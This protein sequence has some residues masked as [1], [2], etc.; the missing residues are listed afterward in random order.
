MY[1]PQ[2]SISFF[3]PVHHL[4]IIIWAMLFTLILYLYKIT[5]LFFQVNFR[6]NFWGKVNKKHKWELNKVSWAIK[7]QCLNNKILIWAN[8]STQSVNI[9]DDLI[10]LH[11]NRLK[12]ITSSSFKTIFS[13]RMAVSRSF[14]HSFFYR[15]NITLLLPHSAVRMAESEC[16]GLA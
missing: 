2:A 16:M 10:M 12:M 15:G 13:V 9:H 5:F 4:F 3:S 1:L 8:I 11:I 7:D 6:R 14:Q